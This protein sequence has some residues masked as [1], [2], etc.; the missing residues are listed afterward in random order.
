MPDM[1]VRLTDLPPVQEDFECRTG[2]RVSIR[3][4]MTYEQG[5]V[6]H[7]IGQM[8]SP[9]WADECRTA[10]GSHPVGC[11]LAITHGRPIG[12]CCFDVTLRGFAGPIGVAREWQRIGIGRTLLVA[13]LTAMRSVGYG[14]SVI[15][16]VASPEFFERACGAVV[17]KSANRDIYPRK[18]QMR[19]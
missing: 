15:G 6:L 8:F 11:F 2:Q 10:F 12:F 17:I 5:Q 1:L 16:N 18:L 13:V 7:W 14:Y 19:D 4:A 3:R 9:T